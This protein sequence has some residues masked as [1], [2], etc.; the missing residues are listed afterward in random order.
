ML[1]LDLRFLEFKIIRVEWMGEKRVVNKIRIF[2]F[3]LYSENIFTISLIFYF[4]F[5]QCFF[6]D[7]AG[8]GTIKVNYI[9]IYITTKH[10]ILQISYHNLLCS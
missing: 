9:H 7:S 8:L 6:E 1:F 4:R 2:K 5:E 10:E 3:K